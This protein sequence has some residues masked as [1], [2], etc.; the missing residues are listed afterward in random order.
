MMINTRYHTYVQIPYQKPQTR[1]KDLNEAVVLKEKND[2]DNDVYRNAAAKAIQSVDIDR[3]SQ[4]T[5][6]L[7]LLVAGR[8]ENSCFNGAM[9]GPSDVDYF[10]VDTT[11]Q[12]LSRRPVIVN[13]EMPKGADYDLTVYDSEGNQVGMAVTNEDGTKTLTIPCDWSSCRNFVIKISQHDPDESVEGRYKLT[14][15]QGDMPEETVKWLERIKGAKIQDNPEGGSRSGA[16]AKEK[17]EAENEEGIL[18]LHKKQFEELPEELKYRGTMSVSELLDLERNGKTLSEAERAYIA[19]YGNQKEIY[20]Q[21]SMKRKW[22]LE[23]E[24][25]EFLE[26]AGLSKKSFEISLPS[27]GNPSVTGLSGE[28][29]RAVEEYITAKR[30]DFQNVYLENSGETAAMTDY[31]YRLAGYVEECD[32]FLGNASGGR[33]SVEDLS[34][35]RNTTGK[36]INEEIAGLPPKVASLVNGADNTGAF[37]DYKQMLYEILQYKEAHGEIPRYHINLSWN[38][39]EITE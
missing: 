5:F 12:I 15:S 21:E 4:G 29:K 38:G 1:L 6:D 17:Y 20:R 8:N 26:S 28:E 30:Q 33:V 10:H 35:R 18:R 37:Y 39:D 16:A 3:Y 31:Q 19:I 23:K 22:G 14:F 27:F 34:I 32:R 25:S 2:G 13:M 7:S 9:N 11:S 24:L 36:M